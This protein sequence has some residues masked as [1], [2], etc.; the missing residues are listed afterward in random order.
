[1]AIRVGL[2]YLQA[3]V[4]ENHPPSVRAILYNETRR[5]RILQCELL[6]PETSATAE[7]LGFVVTITREENCYK[8]LVSKDGNHRCCDFPLQGTGTNWQPSETP[9]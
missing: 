9:L 7:D 2:A 4:W 5:A 6:P 8:V 3:A 1:M